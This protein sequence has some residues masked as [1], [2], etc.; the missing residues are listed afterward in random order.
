[1][2]LPD[3]APVRLAGSVEGSGVGIIVD[4]AQLAVG[5]SDFHG[6]I[7]YVG[8]GDAGRKPRSNAQLVSEYFDR[9]DFQTLAARKST[10]IPPEKFFSDQQLVL[11]WIS[12]NDIHLDYRANTAVVGE[13]HMNNLELTAIAEDGKLVLDG[14]QADMQGAQM[15]VTLSLDAR[16]R[17]YDINYSY[18]LSGIQV[19]RWLKENKVI[20][21]L[22]GEVDIEVKLTGKGNS[23]REVVSHAD[24]YAVMVIHGAKIPRKARIFLPTSVLMSVLRTIN[25]FAAASPVYNIE[26]GLIGFRIDDGKAFSD[27][28]L[29]LKAKEVTVLA[30]G[31]VDLATEEIAIAIRPKAREGLGVSTVDLA[32]IYYRL[33]G[34]LAKPV[35]KAASEPI[36]KTG[37]T[38]GAAWL[39]SG[40]TVLAKSLFDRLG[41]KGDVCKNAANRFDTFLGGTTSSLKP[42]VN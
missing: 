28:T 42:M 9:K 13:H 38:L 40:L 11:D 36:L 19:A 10:G 5:N 32:G 2:S 3:S 34:T 29:A 33:G 1:M 27:H 12:D 8:V 16:Q 39:S 26:C 20:Q 25:P 35:V 14:I 17:P 22:T 21:P 6:S 41:D 30:A 15:T 31:T 37:V 24:G 23:I 7:E 4:S 18:Q